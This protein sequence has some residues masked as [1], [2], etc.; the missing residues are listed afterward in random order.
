MKEQRTQ[1]YPRRSIGV[2]PCIVEGCVR[3]NF[4]LGYCSAHYQ[5]FRRWGDPQAG[6]AE[7]FEE[8][9]WQKVERRGSDDCWLWQA[10]KNQ[11]GYGLVRYPG[12]VHMVGAHRASWMLHNRDVPNG[13]EVL[14]RCDNPPCV[15][16]AHLWLGTQ[17]ENNRDAA[18]KGRTSQGE[19][20][21]MR[22]HGGRAF[23]GK[24]RGRTKLTVENVAEILERRA[25]GE[26]AT[27]IAPKYGITPSTIYA[28]EKG[29]TWRHLSI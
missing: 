26:F 20:H 27:D 3:K 24:H 15:N 21:W 8:R 14:H 9:F 16:P 10:A 23:G 17:A 18:Q 4:G 25:C 11:D 6:R 2:D 19:N 13:L 29:K 12:F 22:N 1:K 28:I 5:R 7:T